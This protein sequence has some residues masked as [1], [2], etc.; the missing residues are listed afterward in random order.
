MTLDHLLAYLEDRIDPDHV[1][2]VE[3]L[4]VEAMD[5]RPVSRL[6]LNVIYPVDER[7]T[8]FSYAVSTQ[9]LEAMLYNELAAIP[10]N[11]L[12][13]VEIG[14]DYPLQ[15]RPNYGIGVIPSLLG[16]QSRIV[17]DNM[18][19]V[20]HLPDLDAL[21]PLLE[22]GVPDLDAGLGRQVRVCL[23]YFREKLAHYPKCAACIRLTQPDLQGPFDNLHLILGNE[24]F[25][26][27]YDEPELMHRA[28]DLITQ[29]YI[30]YRRMIA[31][32]LTGD[33][34]EGRKC[35]V[36][37]AIYG[38]QVVLKE[39][40]ATANISEEMYQE[41]CVPY[42]T[43]ILNEFGGSI[44]FCGARREWHYRQMVAQP[45]R[46]LNFGNPDMHDFARNHALLTD[47]GVCVVGFGENL[48][49]DE[50]AGQFVQDGFC[51]GL[52]L[53][54]RAGSRAEAREVLARHRG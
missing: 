53:M 4:H 47:H 7:V 29:T 22:R 39:D 50:F 43:R 11:V 12:N 38:G 49:Y 27:L 19:W 20:E 9:N 23:E 6:P 32:Y 42:N 54:A 46:C 48:P 10:Y 41:F 8:P 33:A 26:A 16:L 52:T 40:T 17:M 36:H 34:D 25:Y 5:F 44:H 45:L 37:R 15:I 51:T 14:D 21:R 31:P 13:A 35:Y 2:R 1:A 24:L 30:A 18:P 28:L 3:R